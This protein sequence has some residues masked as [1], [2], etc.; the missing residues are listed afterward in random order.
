MAVNTPPLIDQFCGGTGNIISGLSAMKAAGM[1]AAIKFVG[2]ATNYQFSNLS[3]SLASWKAKMDQSFAANNLQ[4]IKAFVNDGTILAN[5]IMDDCQPGSP[6]YGGKPP[7]MEDLDVMA[8][9]SKS[10]WSFMPVTIRVHNSVLAAKSNWTYVD[11]GWMQWHKRFGA[12]GPWYTNEINAGRAVGLGSILGANLL[13][14]GSG[15]TAPWDFDPSSTVS[16]G[17]FCMSP[18]EIDACTAAASQTT[19][20]IGIMCWAS[21]PQF[22]EQG[23]CDRPEIQTS[24]TAMA[25]VFIGKNRGPINYRGEFDPPSSVTTSTSTATV[26]GA[27]GIRDNGFGTITRKNGVVSM[28]VPAPSVYAA[29]D[30]HCLLVYSR[31]SGLSSVTPSGWSETKRFTSGDSSRGGELVLYHKIGSGASELATTVQWPNG[32]G[33][34]GTSQLARWFVLSNGSTILA[35][36]VAATGSG[37]SW[38][39]QTSMG[40]IPGVTSTRSDAIVLIIGAR[41]NDFGGGSV[42]ENWLSATTGPETWGRLFATGTDNGLDAGFF[43]D[44]SS[45]AGIA[46]ITTKSYSL[47]SGSQAG[48]GCGFMVAFAP[49]SVVSGQPAAFSTDFGDTTISVGSNLSFTMTSTGSTPFTYAKVSGPSNVTINSSTGRFD[50]T[51]TSAGTFTIVVSTSNAYGADSDSFNVFAVVQSPTN[52]NAPVITHPGDKTIAEHDLLSFIIQASDPDGDAISYSM[53]QAPQ[54]AFLDTDT[55]QFIWT[56]NARQS[57]IYPI[58]AVVT[59]GRVE[60]RSTFTVTV[61]DSRWGKEHGP[62]SQ[63]EPTNTPNNGFTRLF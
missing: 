21:D 6:V 33:V 53:E 26:T 28:S 7:T 51:P 22:D 18:Q 11:F 48:A 42:D 17:R 43:V 45:P 30:L 8:Q 60:S 36:I 44:Y 13:H 24:L 32:A 20:A 19:Y 9:Y 2:S 49:F 16:T 54:G 23:Y 55:G 61:T 25:N 41:A 40:P 38:P 1:R 58:I 12:V 57:G 47:T 4:Q 62:S 27:W 3:F 14:G 34:P 35:N 15:K 52:N 39:S 59:D 63:F 50:F 5:W 31:D 46:S 37:K 29:G 56:P 10:T